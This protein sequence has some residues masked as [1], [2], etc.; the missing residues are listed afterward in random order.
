MRTVPLLI[1][2]NIF[3]FALRAQTSPSGIAVE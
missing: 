3:I 1:L 2:S